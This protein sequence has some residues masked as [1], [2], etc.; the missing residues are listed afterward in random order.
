MAMRSTTAGAWVALLTQ[1]LWCQSWVAGVVYEQTA[2]GARPLARA[3][4]SVSKSGGEVL[5]TVRT[6]EQGRYTLVDLPA[7][8]LTLLASKPGYLTRQ[9]AGRAGSS[10][11]LD[12]SAGCRESGLDFELSRGAVVAGLVVESMGAPVVSAMVSLRRTGADASSEN[13]TTGSTDDRGRFRIAGLRAGSYTLTVQRRAPGGG[14]EVLRRTVKL[15]I[16]E[17]VADL[18][19]ALGSQESFRV[20]GGV[21]GIP[22]GEGYRTWVSIRPLEGTTSASA[23]SLQAT[24]GPDGRFQFAAVPAGRYS[25]T[26]AVV[27]R[28][29]A[30]RIDHLLDVLEVAGETDHV[31]LQPVQLATLTASV[32]IAAGTLP[33]SAVIR[34]TSQEGFGSNWTKLSGA[35]RRFEF[36]GL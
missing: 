15:G 21:A 30:E 2:Q 19:L 26:A 5:G 25:A 34:F 31:I 18:S 33:A 8:R 27:K 6:D 29:T 14:E 9:A 23:R 4:V 35:G 7:N 20:A 36:R 22:F 24:V 12:C 13:P 16:G 28:G 11:V 3:F 1:P 10:A 32:E 17:Q